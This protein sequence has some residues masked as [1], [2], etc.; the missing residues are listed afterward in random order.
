MC[1]AREES[2]SQGLIRGDREAVM[3]GTGLWEVA[4]GSSRESLWFDSAI[5]NLVC[6]SSRI[7]GLSLGLSVHSLDLLES[8]PSVLGEMDG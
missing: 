6:Y 2:S 7:A 5:F 3:G 8:L 1:V 4:L